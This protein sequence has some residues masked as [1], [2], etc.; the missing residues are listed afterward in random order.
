MRRTAT[1]RFLAAYLAMVTGLRAAGQPTIPRQPGGPQAPFPGRP[2]LAQT[3]LKVR[4]YLPDH[5]GGHTP[6]VSAPA[7]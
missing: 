4:Q 2:P 6:A 3:G 1:Q 7:A 5:A